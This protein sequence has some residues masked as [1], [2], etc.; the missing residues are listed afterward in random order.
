MDLADHFVP[1]M[2]S[3]TRSIMSD[4]R[5]NLHIQACAVWAPSCHV[6]VCFVFVSRIQ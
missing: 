3:S 5:G 6:C 4:S 2:Y 1:N